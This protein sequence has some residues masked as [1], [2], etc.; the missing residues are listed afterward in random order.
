M[1]SLI[2]THA[3]LNV[4]QYNKNID[5][6]LKRAKEKGVSKIIVIGMDYKTSIRAIDLANKYTNLY[7]TVGIHPSYVDNCCHLKLNDL[8]KSKKVIAVGEIGIDLYH[9]KDNKLLQEKVFEEQV[10]KAI[11]LDLPVIIHTRNSFD[12]AYN[13][14][15]KYKGK[16]KGVFHCFSSNLQD[17]KKVIDLGFYI[18]I[19]GPIT[20]QN[21]NKLLIDI[22]NNISLDKILIETDSPY[23]T[24]NPHRGKINEPANVYYVAKEIASIKNIS[25]NEVIKQTTI[26]ANKLFKLEEIR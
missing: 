7:A 5:E 14:L 10:Q 4:R 11:K 26:N 22:I 17:A 12:E 1:V 6:I 20:Y 15:K 18:G 2:D 16:V 3:H 21:S 13:I 23:L 19:D 24:P 8:Y 9:R 25:L